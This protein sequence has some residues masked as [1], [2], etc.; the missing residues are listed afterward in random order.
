MSQIKRNNVL[1]NVEALDE[2]TQHII[3]KL[4]AII[5][6]DRNVDGI[7]CNKLV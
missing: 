6:S 7:S 2:E 1:A 3:D 4:N 5:T